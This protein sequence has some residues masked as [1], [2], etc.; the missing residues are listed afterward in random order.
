MLTWF[1]LLPLLLA[2]QLSACGSDAVPSASRA[3]QRPGTTLI[4]GRLFEEHS[5]LPIDVADYNEIW[6]S[7]RK[8]AMLQQALGPVLIQPL[9]DIVADYSCASCS[10]ELAEEMYRE[11]WEGRVD[12]LWNE[13]F[14][15]EKGVLHHFWDYLG[16]G[17]ER[18][19]VFV[20][21]LSIVRFRN[22][23]L[24]KV[25]E[26]L[27][28]LVAGRVPQ[29]EHFVACYLGFSRQDSLNARVPF[30]LVNT[31]FDEW[32]QVLVEEPRRLLGAERTVV[33]FTA[34]LQ[35]FLVQRDL[36]RAAR[37][38]S[39]LVESMVRDDEWFCVFHILYTAEP[40]LVRRFFNAAILL[41]QRLLTLVLQSAA[42]VAMGVDP[43]LAKYLVAMA[44]KFCLAVPVAKPSVMM[45]EL[46]DNAKAGGNV[47]MRPLTL[48]GKTR[49]GFWYRA[50]S[51]RKTV[52]HS[53]GV[54]LY[55]AAGNF[56]EAHSSSE[57]RYIYIRNFQQA[58]VSRGK[59]AP[60]R[61]L[62]GKVQ[63]GDV[64]VVHNSA[65]CPSFLEAKV[66]CT[67]LSREECFEHVKSF[68]HAAKD[69]NV[70]FMAIVES[71]QHVG[72]E[73][74]LVDAEKESGASVK[75][76]K[77]RGERGKECRSKQAI[78]S[79]AVGKGVGE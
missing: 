50:S 5:L 32:P 18:V 33:T 48:V 72:N 24:N 67:G 30:P 38:I 66:D 69:R 59:L 58:E 16:G 56:L 60:G 26:N 71:D 22:P 36:K 11:L 20:H 64:I 37:Y 13:L 62:K 35:C 10:R 68:Y 12:G 14:D 70:R 7:R 28:I 73:A 61:L 29:T 53:I 51:T 44:S 77:E 57:R 78:K 45:E 40:A 3:F 55:V 34:A 42:P 43:T 9:I 15:V 65:A 52:A 4:S 46:A 6:N 49:I 39:I 1:V 79:V 8:R 47:H 23:R 17:A 25:L 31:S 2:A 54:Q 76:G 27:A 41:G 74:E 21:M 75:E 19:V 63:H